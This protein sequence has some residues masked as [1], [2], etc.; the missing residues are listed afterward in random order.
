MDV[1]CSDKTGTLTENKLNLGDPFTVEEA[2]AQEVILAASLSSRAENQDTIDLAVLT[3]VKNGQIFKEYRILH[4]L[5]FDLVNKRTGAIVETFDGQ[6]FKVTKGAPQVILDLSSNADKVRPA[7]EEAN[8]SFSEHG[9]RSLGAARTD[10][11]D[12][13]RFLG[14]FLIKECIKLGAYGIFDSK[15]VLNPKYLVR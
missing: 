10:S 13:W 1:L 7:T 2:N 8:N 4:F 3:G 11:Q 5:P 12:Q 15:P 14:V 6:S 9:F